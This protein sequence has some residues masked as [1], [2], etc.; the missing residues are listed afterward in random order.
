MIGKI[1]GGVLGGVLSGPLGVIVGAIIGHF[2]IDRPRKASA[3]RDKFLEYVCM[4]IAKVAKVDGAITQSEIDEIEMLF[5][6]FNF[7]EDTR[8]KAI[9]AFRRA[10]NS[11]WDAAFITKTFASDFHD[12]NSRKIFMVCVCR[13]ALSDGNLS[14]SE[15][16]TLTSMAHI[17]SLNLSEFIS[18]QRTRRHNEA[19][20]N[21]SRY[22]SSHSSVSSDIDWAYATLGV[23]ASASDEEI[24]KLYHR[25]C[26][27]LHP[28]ILRS[29]GLGEFAI[30]ALEQEL[31][32]VNDAYDAIKKHRR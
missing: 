6:E 21:S 13:V 18:V 26:K 4:A 28:D 30:K 12:V 27:E 7:D 32:R 8:L 17:L 10:K 1:I 15:L 24:K 31:S 11:S 9:D 16:Q 5:R 25:K 19:G 22:S 2:T 3:N 20:E 14:E 23:S 29:R